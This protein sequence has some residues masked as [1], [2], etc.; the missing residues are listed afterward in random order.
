MDSKKHHTPEED[1][2]ILPVF[3]SVA[4]KACSEYHV[5]LEPDTR[6]CRDAYFGTLLEISNSSK[7]NPCPV[8]DGLKQ[9]LSGRLI[10]VLESPHKDEYTNKELKEVWPIQGSSGESFRRYLHMVI[11]DVMNGWGVFVVNAIQYQCSQGLNLKKGFNRAAKNYV[12]GNL[13]LNLDVR[14]SLLRRVRLFYETID[15]MPNLIL[16]A[17][18]SYVAYN[19]GT[20]NKTLVNE[21]L[22]SISSVVTFDRVEHPARWPIT[23]KRAFWKDQLLELYNHRFKKECDA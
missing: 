4:E 7:L 17:C 20:S 18:T 15:G 6:P 14:D 19:I 13:L 21:I 5:C 10:F 2:D 16:N 23:R 1:G 9:P 3:L 12:V 11:P 22:K 8:E